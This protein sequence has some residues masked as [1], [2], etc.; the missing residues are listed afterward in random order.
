MVHGQSGVPDVYCWGVH[1][2][3]PRV[4]NIYRVEWSESKTTL[5]FCLGFA[6][7]EANVGTCVQA[8]DHHFILPSPE[9]R[10]L[11]RVAGNGQRSTR[12]KLYL[13]ETEAFQACFTNYAPESPHPLALSA[14][15]QGSN[16]Q[17][18]QRSSS[19]TDSIAMASSLALSQNMLL[20]TPGVGITT[21]ISGSFGQ[22]TDNG[23]W[24][25]P[26]LP[27]SGNTSTFPQPSEVPRRNSLN[28]RVAGAEQAIPV[29]PVSS[30]DLGLP[31]EDYP[32]NYAF[33]ET[34]SSPGGAPPAPRAKYAR[35]RNR[36]SSRS[37]G[38][39]FG[40]D[41]R[42]EQIDDWVDQ[43]ATTRREAGPVGNSLMKC[44]EAG[45]SSRPRRPHALKVSHVSH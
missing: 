4:S 13:D 19:P 41:A 36:A 32:N 23:R 39:F 8:M 22:V 18:P 34:N 28:T 9:G 16:P 6:H 24:Q 5:H 10:E 17:L 31:G 25:R 21:S 27:S 38:K 11:Y 12:V 29:P 43:T 30:S 26:E 45:C 1:P 15:F 35:L 3:A 42:R 44:P 20:E 14:D 40:V 33:L 2:A 7:L 37:P